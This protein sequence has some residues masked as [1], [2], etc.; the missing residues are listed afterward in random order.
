MLEQK[1][2]RTGAMYGTGIAIEAAKDVGT[3]TAAGSGS[4][5]TG[6]A[7]STLSAASNTTPTTTTIRRTTTTT[8]TTRTEEITTT[9]GGDKPAKACRRCGQTNHQWPTSK[10]C[11]FFQSN[12]PKKKRKQNNNEA[13][14]NS[15]GT[16]K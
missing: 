9:P 13:D 5:A 2:K 6:S 10:K 3:I 8:T 12:R 16:D 4:G 11:P 1:A 7:A 14:K 15:G